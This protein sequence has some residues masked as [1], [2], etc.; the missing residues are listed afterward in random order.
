MGDYLRYAMFDK[1]FKQIG[2]CVGAVDLPGRHRQG[3]GA[4]PDVLVLRLGRRDRPQRGLV[5][6][7][8]FQPQPLRLPE[9]AG[10]LGA[11]QRAPSCGRSRRPPSPT[12][13]RSFERQLEFYTWLQSAEGGIAGGATNSWDGSYAQP[14][15]GTPTFY[16][17]FYDVAAGLPRPAVATS[18]SACRC[19]RCSGSRSYYY[20]T[21]N[22][23]GQGD[24]RQVGRR[25]R[26][27]TP[28][29]VRAAAFEIPS[30]MTWSGAPA[31][32]NPTIA[33]AEHRPARHGHQDGPGRR[34]RGA[35]T[36][37]P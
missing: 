30:D 3:L 11:D 34:R 21:G 12:G 4:L 27:P 2:N 24:A 9:P 10:G 20:A 28:P 6:A 16:G 23:A 35:R 13:P 37:G 29:S 26:S 14:P 17:M 22:A 7:D 32:W 8:R 25:G 5:V 1:Y 36:P 19:G 31:T 18:G 33:G 15:A